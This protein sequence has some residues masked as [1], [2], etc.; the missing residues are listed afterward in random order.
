MVAD[1]AVHGAE[2]WSDR[3]RL[4]AHGLGAAGLGLRH[5]AAAGAGVGIRES[6]LTSRSSLVGIPSSPSGVVVGGVVGVG[7]DRGPDEG[8]RRAGSMDSN[9]DVGWSKFNDNEHL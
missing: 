9:S 2:G 7:V 3:R 6:S 4:H 1:P 8:S 5:L